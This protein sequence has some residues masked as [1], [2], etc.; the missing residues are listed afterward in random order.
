MYIVGRPNVGKSA[1]FNRVIGKPAA[2]VYDYPGV[3]RDRLYMRA[4]WGGRE[5]VLIDTGGLMSEATK[6]PTEQAELAM[7]EVSA[8]N[9]PFAIERQAAAGAAYV[10]SP[11]TSWLHSVCSFVLL[12]VPFRP[13]VD[14][15]HSRPCHSAPR[16]MAHHG[17]TKQPAKI[18][19]SGGQRLSEP[20]L[21]FRRSRGRCGSDAVRWPGRAN[22]AGRRDHSVAATT[23]PQQKGRAG[24]QQVREHYAG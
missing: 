23:S 11:A 22:S 24:R 7:A 15:V 5:F 18:M 8:E 9:L 19:G 20:S 1:L 4:N 21:M 12:A 16:T 2:I 3:T 14:R 13:V 10:L 17:T 6:L